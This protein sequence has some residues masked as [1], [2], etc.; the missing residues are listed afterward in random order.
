MRY[1]PDTRKWT[2]SGR[3]TGKANLQPQVVQLDAQHLITYMRRAG[4]YL[5]TQHGYMLRAESH[6]GGQTWSK[7]EATAFPQSQCRGG[8]Y[9]AAEWPFDAGL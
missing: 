3:I 6:D 8:F 9:P 7:A 1:S 5:P 2:E 4:G